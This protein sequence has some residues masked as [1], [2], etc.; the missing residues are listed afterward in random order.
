MPGS[1]AVDMTGGIEGVKKRQTQG[2]TGCWDEVWALRWRNFSTS[3]LSVVIIW[4]GPGSGVIAC[5]CTRR[6]GYYIQ[7]NTD[8]W[9]GKA[10]LANL[11]WE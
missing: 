3:E 11:C 1:R 10:G 4:S 8:L 7:I 2:C 9:I 6:Q 5:S